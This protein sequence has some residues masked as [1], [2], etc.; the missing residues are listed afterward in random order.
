MSVA[1]ST[2]I[3]PA[4]KGTSL[5]VSRGLDIEG[6]FDRWIR[7][8]VAGGDVALNTTKAYR[9]AA[10]AFLAWCASEGIAPLRV[11]RG[12]VVRY[13]HVLKEKGRSMATRNLALSVLR[14][15]YE[16]LQERGLCS[17]NPAR[18]VR[19]G[20]DLTDASEKILVS[21][22]DQLR[23]LL[24]TMPAGPDVGSLRD[25]AIVALMVIEGVRRQEVSDLNVTSLE[26]GEPAILAVW[27]KGRKLR[28]V[29]MEPSLAAGIERYLGALGSAEV[30]PVED[31]SGVPLFVRLQ[32]TYDRGRRL[33]EKSIG[34]ITNQ[35]LCAAGLREPDPH[36]RGR[37]P[38]C[39]ALRH[40]MATAAA[41]AA[42]PLDILS[43]HLGHSNL[44]TTQIY[45]HRS[46][47]RANAPALKVGV[48]LDVP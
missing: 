3:V 44:S 20:R 13:R 18:N 4:E 9:R 28:H 36:G 21:S 22:V 23:R 16:A 48:T 7:L 26:G 12:D 10:R 45:L 41:E 37:Q 27:G 15:L 33:G 42:V 29:I 6:E 47:R 2:Q 24:G 31:E 30:V 19:A 1:D 5:V 38:S 39:H 11:T 46:Q 25:R 35:A 43:S 17:M 14:R 8:E 32:R 34:N 40:S